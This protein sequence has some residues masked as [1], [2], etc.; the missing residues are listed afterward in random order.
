MALAQM[1][2]MDA[3]DGDWFNRGEALHETAEDLEP[4]HDSPVRRFVLTLAAAAIGM[5]AFVTT[6]IVLT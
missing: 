3:H 5:A 1:T 6:A 2:G 4:L